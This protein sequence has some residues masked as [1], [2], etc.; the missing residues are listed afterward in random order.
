MILGAVLDRTGVMNL[1]SSLILKL[2]GPREWRVRTM[3]AASVGLVS[4]FMQNVGVTA[5]FMPVVSRLLARLDISSS[6]VLIPVSFCALVGGSLAVLCSSS[7][8]LL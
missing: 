8:L 7:L 5:I 2:G 1:V 3:L 6:R 4:G